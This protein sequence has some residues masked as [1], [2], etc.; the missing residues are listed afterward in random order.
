MCSSRPAAD[1]EIRGRNRTTRAQGVL[2][3]LPTACSTSG[4]R[5]LTV[6]LCA[7]GGGPVPTM[8]FCSGEEGAP[9]LVREEQFS[10]LPQ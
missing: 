5:D 2:L 3:I 7:S 1:P 9:R 4:C 6:C 8:W 10:C